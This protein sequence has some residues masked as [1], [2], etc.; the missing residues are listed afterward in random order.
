LPDP[1]Q[2]EDGYRAVVGPRKFEMALSD[3]DWG[4]A[5]R[6]ELETVTTATRTIVE[7]D[8]GDSIRTH[9]KWCTTTTS[10]PNIRGED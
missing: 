3:L 8:K 2:I 9:K 4:E 5:A 7:V 10:N 6:T 1:H